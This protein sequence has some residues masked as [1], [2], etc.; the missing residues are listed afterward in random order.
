[1]KT[2][3]DTDIGIEP[4]EEALICL[5]CESKRCTP[6]NCERYREGIK[7]INGRRKEELKKVEWKWD[8]G[9]YVPLCPYCSELAYEEDHCIFCG[10][11]Y[12]W[13][14]GE[15]KPAV[16]EHEG[17]KAV[18]ASNNHVT[19][20]KDGQMIMHSSCKVKKTEDELKADIE[21]VKAMRER[22]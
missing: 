14:D 2:T 17:Y 8:W 12:K 10:K 7:K 22:K 18:Q 9:V 19:I 21:F 15:Y 16:V 6:D 20:Y 11:R 5:T 4:S 3:I 13:V 1:M